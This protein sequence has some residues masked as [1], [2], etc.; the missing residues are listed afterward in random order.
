LRKSFSRRQLL[1]QI[2]QTAAAA[3][4]TG[5][6]PRAQG[7]IGTRI[8]RRRNTTVLPSLYAF[9][10]NKNDRLG[11]SAIDNLSSPVF[12]STTQWLKVALSDTTN[13]Y[14]APDKTLWASGIDERNV[15]L[16]GDGTVGANN[17]LP[18][19][20][21]AESWKEIATN[22]R[23]TLAIKDDGTLWS[24][25]ANDFGQLGRLELGDSVASTPVFI[26]SSTNWL[27]LSA[28]FHSTIINAS[29]ELY[30]TGAGGSGRLGL[31]ST[32]SISS[33]TRV[34]STNWSQVST[35][36]GHTLAIASDGTL[37]AWGRRTTGALGDG[38]SSGSVSTPKQVSSLTTWASVAAG[39][40]LGYAIKTDGT[41]WF[42]GYGGNRSSGLGTNTNY[43]S[44][45]QVGTSFAK[46]FSRLETVAAIKTD[47]TLWSWGSSA[48]YRVGSGVTTDVSTPVQISTATNWSSVSIG[49]EHTLGIQSDGTL[50][51]W[52]QNSEGELGRGNTTAIS[53]PVRIGTGSA[54][55]A[56]ASGDYCS[57]GI[58]GGALYVWGYLAY[59]NNTMRVSTPMQIG[60]ETDW[61]AVALSFKDNYFAQKTNGDLYGFG[62]NYNGGLGLDIFA[63]VSSP[64]QIGSAT[65][66][67]KIEISDR[68][69]LALKSTGTI[70]Q[71]GWILP[72][73][74]DFD[75]NYYDITLYRLRTPVQLGSVSTW[76]Q[77]AANRGVH[78]SIRTDNSL[79][80]WGSASPLA[81][82]M[83]THSSTPTRIGAT[84]TWTSIAMGLGAAAAIRSDGTLWS[85]GFND[86]G[87]LGIGTTADK[88]APT[89]VGADTWTAVAAGT[90]HFLGIRTTGTAYGWGAGTY[91]QIGNSAVVNKSSPVQI[92]AATDWKKIWGGGNGS[93]GTR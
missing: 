57:M 8:S 34:G 38:G 77:I 20:V 76:S 46:V 50:W 49:S 3:C 31:G 15:G 17:I 32:T 82:N 84:S 4:I 55:T 81:N 47:G 44:F 27:S 58:S 40:D 1:I 62:Y 25:G 93:M 60:T 22:D 54:W 71:W 72:Q 14:I 91:G 9:G 52:G 86:V 26:A 80:V 78:M 23:T 41:L 33:L 69:A 65:N 89:A 36:S 19:Q 11:V 66:W 42:T 67:T 2:A 48:N 53:T 61:S 24:W 83:S 79:W 16:P 7:F 28:M 43:S 51:G 18:T 88:S 63:R 10:N 39:Y 73:Y 56:V 59:W 85:W 6:F 5:F 30:V 70:S 29:G 74:S 68:T 92:G 37:W 12:H 21:S 64:V 45:V 90:K 35:G 87:Q 13:Y 75:P